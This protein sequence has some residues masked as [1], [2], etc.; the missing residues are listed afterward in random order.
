MEVHVAFEPEEGDEE[1]GGQD[2]AWLP[3]VVLEVP[4]GDQGKAAEE[5]EEGLELGGMFVVRLLSS[6]EVDEETGEADPGMEVAPDFVRWIAE[7][8][9]DP[10]HPNDVQAGA[11]LLCW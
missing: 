8:E 11:A 5:E 7:L 3:A 4:G 6:P 9:G 10:V 1:A 2:G